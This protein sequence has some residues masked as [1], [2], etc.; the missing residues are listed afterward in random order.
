MVRVDDVVADLQQAKNLRILVLDSCRDNPLADELKRSTG[1]K[2]ALPLQQGL[3]KIDSPQGMIIAYA[4]Q[5]GRTADDGDGRNSPYTKAFL[6]NI[7]TQE[8]IGM[9]F[10]LISADVFKATN[11][12]Q[13]PE[14]SISLPSLYYLKQPPVSPPPQSVA[15][16]KPPTAGNVELD[17]YR[18][19]SEFEATERSN[20]PAA[21][22][23]FLDR[24]PT[25]TYGQIARLRLSKSCL[26]RV[27]PLDSKYCNNIEE[28][29]MSYFPS[30]TDP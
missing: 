22:H 6:K 3:A 19:M 17:D 24:H 20:S 9:I 12:N 29:P 16:P 15:A 27:R 4:T 7:E 30:P 2:R 23:Q 21:W 11:Q 26:K 13:L 28:D 8:E 1:T 14:L 10:R 25:G 5:A 18:V